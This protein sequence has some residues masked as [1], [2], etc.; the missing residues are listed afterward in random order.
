M[1]ELEKSFF[2]ILSGALIFFFF[3]ISSM[4]VILLFFPKYKYSVK[5]F[6]EYLAPECI[7]SAHLSKVLIDSLCLTSFELKL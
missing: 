5:H 1:H 2:L 4:Q 7:A 3:L 6:T